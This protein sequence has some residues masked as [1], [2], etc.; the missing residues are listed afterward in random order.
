MPPHPGMPPQYMYPPQHPQQIPPPNAQAYQ[1]AN[2]NSNDVASAL[3]S[4]A[5]DF[6]TKGDTQNSEKIM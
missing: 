5:Q 4:V 6:Q 1:R 3:M 2:T